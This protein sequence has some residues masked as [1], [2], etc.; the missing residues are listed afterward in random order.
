MNFVAYTLALPGS[1]MQKSFEL[2]RTTIRTFPLKDLPLILVFQSR[3]PGDM[4]Q[5]SRHRHRR[6]GSLSNA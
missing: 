2:S 6:V 5:R 3:P 4:R 1:R